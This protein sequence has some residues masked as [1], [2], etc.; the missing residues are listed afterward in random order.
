MQLL[1]VIL[2][3]LG[4]M[5]GYGLVNANAAVILATGGC[6][7][8]SMSASNITETSLDIDIISSVG[9]YNIEYGLTG[10]SQ[11]T[12]TSVGGHTSNTFSVSGLA[13]GT[14]YDFYI[15]ADCGSDSSFWIGSLTETT[16]TLGLVTLGTGTTVN[17]TLAAGLINIYYR[18]LRY[19]TVYTAAEIAAAGG[20]AGSITY[21]GWYVTAV[22]LY[23]LPNY[24]IN[25][26][27]ITA[28]D[29]IAHDGTGLTTV[30]TNANYTPTAGG[31][32][33]LLLQTPFAWNGI[34]NIS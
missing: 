23:G 27:H 20:T 9:T 26:K 28:T 33:M 12:G 25:I 11:G 21:L 14:T 5:K 2:T 32:D 18:S 6:L 7:S 29:A 22:P 19:Q 30:Y 10:F 13:N 24:T 8:P 15:Q 3:E 17:S 31:F 16:F 1:E 34:D 4:I